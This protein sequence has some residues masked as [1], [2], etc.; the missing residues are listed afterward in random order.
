MNARRKR[1][2]FDAA[3]WTASIVVTALLLADAASAEGRR[4][5]IDNATYRNECGSCHVAFPP[6][7]LGA[8]SWRAVMQ[9]LDRHFGVDASVEAPARAEIA[10]YLQ[11][12]AGP[13]RKEA[14]TL[15][16]SETTWFRREHDE[17][18]P[19]SWK[20]A[21]VKSAANCGACHTQADRGDFSERNIRIPR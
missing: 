8:G 5:T 6:A 2:W 19:R 9:G 20:A 10:A 11:R 16:I 13:A 14:G 18:S 4:Y 12:A 7:L 21:A 15:R 17:V 3:I 1:I